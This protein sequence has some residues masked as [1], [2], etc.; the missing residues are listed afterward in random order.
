MV[1]STIES[2]ISQYPISLMTAHQFYSDYPTNSDTAFTTGYLSGGDLPFGFVY[3][4]HNVPNGSAWNWRESIRYARPW[5][6]I[7]NNAALH[8]GYSSTIPVEEF[9][10]DLPRGLAILHE[11]STTSIYVECIGSTFLELW[12]LY[13]DIPLITP[14]QPSWTPLSTTPPAFA[15]TVD[16]TPTVGLSGTGSLS[17]DTDVVGVRVDLTTI[18]SYVGSQSGTPLTYYEIGWIAFGDSDGYQS[19]QWITGEHWSVFPNPSGTISTVGYSLNP[20]VVATITPLLR[21]VT[22]A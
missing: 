1:V 20:G 8:G 4:L 6:H 5:G 19:R 16:G 13:I 14:T 12:G 2:L 9:L 7:V 22:P 15:P 3:E 21:N 11:P 10:L 18:P 17:L